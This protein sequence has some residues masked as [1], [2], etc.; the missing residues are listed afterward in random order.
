MVAGHLE[1]PRLFRR[2]P[3]SAGP[4]RRQSKRLGDY[5]P[6]IKGPPS[7]QPFLQGKGNVPVR[8]PGFVKIGFGLG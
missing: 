6:R 1:Q 5:E 8:Y 4:H 7:A 3:R 2:Q